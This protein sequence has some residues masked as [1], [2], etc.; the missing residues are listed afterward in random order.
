MVTRSD[1]E[2]D[3]LKS[4]I[5]RKIEPVSMPAHTAYPIRNGSRISI[6]VD[7]MEHPLHPIDV[8]NIARAWNNALSGAYTAIMQEHGHED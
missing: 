7:G 1:F 2:L 6:V 4:R 3:A 5:S 8:A